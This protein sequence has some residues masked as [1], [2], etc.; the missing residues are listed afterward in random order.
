MLQKNYV[1]TDGSDMKNNFKIIVSQTRVVNVL[2]LLY[3]LMI[4]K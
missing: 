2:E 1:K 3:H 4:E